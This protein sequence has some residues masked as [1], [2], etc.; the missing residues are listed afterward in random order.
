MF[1]SPYGFFSIGLY[2]QVSVGVKQ[3]TKM[4]MCPG[5]D[6]DELES[7]VESQMSSPT[8]QLM[9]VDWR[10]YCQKF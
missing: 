9:I 6:W 4:G 10:G 2:I 8:Q 3:P 1:G 7:H 5:G